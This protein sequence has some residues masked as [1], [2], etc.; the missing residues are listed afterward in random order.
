M[1]VEALFAGKPH[2]FG[3][4]Q[5]PSSIIKQPFTELHIKHDGAVED[6]QGNKKLHGGPEM[7][8][9]QFAQESYAILQKQ[10]PA[11]ANNLVHGSIGEN[12]SA[13][14][15]NDTNVF[16]G[17]IYRIGEVVLEVNSPRAPCSKINQR[18]AVKNMDLFIAEHGITGWYYRVIETGKMCV[19]DKVELQHRLNQTCSIKEVMRLV[20]NKDVTSPEKANA[21]S[22]NGLAKEWVNKLTK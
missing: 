19:G 22:I 20:R 2:P 6:E 7:A 16:I 9:H 14:G 17:D 4:R 5:S 21:A 3:P 1:F 13:A 8:M 15:M 12:I 18:Y 10:F 11:F